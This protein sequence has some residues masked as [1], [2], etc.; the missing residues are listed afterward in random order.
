MAISSYSTTPAS[1]TSISGINIAEGC[2]PS[3]INDAIRQMMADIATDAVTLSG[4]QTLTNK[5]LTSPTVSGGTMNNAIIGGTTPAAGTF[6]TVNAGA[7]GDMGTWT[8]ST[9]SSGHIF[10]D[11]S[12]GSSRIGT[13]S[14]AFIIDVASGERARVDTNGYLLVGYTS[15]NGAYKLQVN[16]QIFATSATIATSDR[17][18]KENIESLKDGLSVI[19]KLNPVTYTFKRDDVQDFPTGT[20]AG[21]IAQDVQDAAS[22]QPY[23]DSI[24]VTNTPENGDPFLGLADNMLIPVLV[25]AIQELSAKIERLETPP[26]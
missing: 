13:R 18:F 14:G 10:A 12:G 20:L 19:N 17:K 6:T 3:G 11:S 7:A 9:T 16:S 26:A 22:G 24:V 21:F 1:N 5:T 15:S 25:K 8:S 4:S 2:A 23:A